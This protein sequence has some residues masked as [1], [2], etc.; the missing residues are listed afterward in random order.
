[1]PGLFKEPEGGQRGSGRNVTTG[2][3]V[4]GDGGSRGR[5]TSDL[6]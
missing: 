5:V 1:M 2:D 4:E 6:P 3:E